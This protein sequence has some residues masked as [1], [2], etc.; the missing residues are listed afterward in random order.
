MIAVGLSSRVIKCNAKEFVPRVLA[1]ILFMLLL[2]TYVTLSHV[3]T[4][5]GRGKKGY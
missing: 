4:G 5:D 1:F 3:C 2:V